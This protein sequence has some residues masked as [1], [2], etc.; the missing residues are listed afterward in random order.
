[1]PFHRLIFYAFIG[2]IILNGG[3]KAQQ[4]PY[5]GVNGIHEDWAASGPD[6]LTKQIVKDR[7]NV[8]VYS[9]ETHFTLS[10]FVIRTSTRLAQIFSRKIKV[11]KIRSPEELP[12][13]MGELMSRHPN[14][15]IGDLWIDSHGTYRS[16]RS[17]FM[18]G[19]DTVNFVTMDEPRIRKS[20][21]DIS[22]Y[23]DRSSYV[24]LGA[25]YGSATYDR[26]SNHI[27]SSSAMQGDSLLL[28]LGKAFPRTPILASQSWVMTKPFMFG[29][30]WGISG[31]PLGRRFR[32]EI[33]R[34][35]WEQLGN[36]RMLD[37]DSGTV[38][39]V[40]TVSLTSIGDIRFNDI[41]YIDQ[42]KHLRKRSKNLAKLKPGLYDR[43]LL[44]N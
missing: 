38:R 20:L 13:K 31:Y 19:F 4:T 14:Q 26:P 24:T 3:L 7:V 43:K 36:W 44:E 29:S 40:N 17:L 1:M 34:P 6:S 27:L 12:L 2:L 41:N 37:P 9:K 22:I 39:D 10:S 28:Q 33:F 18:L 30:K 42:K 23:C 8:F 21:Q 16:G 35:V 32:D 15:M 5:S 11:L 25:C